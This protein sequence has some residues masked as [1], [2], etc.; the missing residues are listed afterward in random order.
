MATIGRPST[1]S[2]DAHAGKGDDRRRDR[3]LSARSLLIFAVA[4]LLGFAAG[5]SVGLI[6]LSAA[7]GVVGNTGGVLAGLVVGVGGWCVATLKLAE[8]LDRL[9]R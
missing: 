1:D 9:V 5:V 4:G 3:L 2:E 8:I 7:R 6:T